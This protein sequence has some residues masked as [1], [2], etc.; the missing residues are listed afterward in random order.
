MF[1]PCFF[2]KK[3]LANKNEQGKS[4]KTYWNCAHIRGKIM[5]LNKGLIWRDMDNEIKEHFDCC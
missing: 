1:Y 5:T 2:D 3:S 4:W